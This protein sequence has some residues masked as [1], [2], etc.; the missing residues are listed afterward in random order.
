MRT[1]RNFLFN[2]VGAGLPLLL[3]IVAVPLIARHAGYERLGFLTIVWAA[4]GYLGFLDFGLSRVFARR[5][6]VAEAAGDLA[7]EVAFMRWTARRLFTVCSAVAVVVAL[8]V[9]PSWLAGAGA[10]ASWLWEVRVAWVILAASIPALV[11]SNVWRGAMEGRGAFGVAN[12]FRVVMGAW[13]FG[14]PL[15]LLPFTP[16]LPALVG[17]VVLGRWFSLVLHQ[18]WCRRHLPWNRSASATDTVARRHELR[19]TLAEG[20]WVTV[21]GVVGPVMV[22]FDRFLLGALAA[23]ASVAVYAVPQE[24][25]LRMLL[26]PGLLASVLFPRLA[27]LATTDQTASASLIN[28][29]TRITIV[30]QLPLCLLMEWQALP[31]LQAWVGAQIAAPAAP[32]FRWLLVGCIVNTA[33]QVP[34]AHLQAS[35]RSHITARIHLAEVLPYCAVLWWAVARDGA[36]GAAWVWSARCGVDTVL[37]LLANARLDARV[38]S[39]RLL[40]TLAGG[41]AATLA[42]AF[43]LQGSGATPP[44]P[45][46]Q[47]ALF[48]ALAS[49]AVALT[50]L[51]RKDAA[52]LLQRLSRAG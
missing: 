39:A 40:L 2:L 33:A 3:A 25:V 38:L 1:G 20:A 7:A 18:G 47:C 35:G 16:G 52:D 10:S 43:A 23:L 5:V 24:I 29:A 30:M 32:I 21:S 9:P 13:T 15:L 31:L 27:V 48:I 36:L 42:A 28:R 26:V 51:E 22:V 11:L 37:M 50:G 4:I 6:A 19:R 8:A 44:F 46:W 12:V 17:G 49:G 41:L 45:A 34:F 14:A